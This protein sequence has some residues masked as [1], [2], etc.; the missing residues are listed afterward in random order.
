[1]IAA[2]VTEGSKLAQQLVMAGLKP[3]VELEL[4]NVNDLLRDLTGLL[5][6]TFPVTVEIITNL[7]PRIPNIRMN[8]GQLNR[9]IL[10]LLINA[11]T[12]LST[13]GKS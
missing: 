7:D 4:G 1:M 2:T 5:S 11:G 6:K 10:N 3:T 13:V 9:A 8:P 12:R